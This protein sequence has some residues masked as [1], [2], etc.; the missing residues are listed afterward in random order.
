MKWRVHM[1]SKVVNVCRWLECWSGDYLTNGTRSGGPDNH[2][3]HDSRASEG[4][5]GC[6]RPRRQGSRSALLE[7]F[8]VITCTSKYI[9]HFVDLH[10]CTCLWQKTTKYAAKSAKR[11]GIYLPGICGIICR[12]LRIWTKSRN[13]LHP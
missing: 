7:A 8:A 9:K 2:D 1:T 12:K 11:C 13:L 5:M 3:C 4:C 6:G 10:D